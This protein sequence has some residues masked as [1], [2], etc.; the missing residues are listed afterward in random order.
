VRIE[1]S[2]TARATTRCY[3][4]DQDGMRTIAVAVGALAADPS[5]PDAFIRGD[6]RRLKVGPYRVMY[7][8]DDG[9]LTIER[10]DR[11]P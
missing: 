11:V 9:I 7:V 3:L 8:V 1:W 6:Y 2:P 10:V 5:P 4:G